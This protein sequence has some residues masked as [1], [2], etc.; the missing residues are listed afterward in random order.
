MAT[1]KKT[2]RFN[3]NDFQQLLAN[4]EKAKNSSAS[5]PSDSSSTISSDGTGNKARQRKKT[6]ASSSQ[7]VALP[8]NTES[9]SFNSL[10]DPSAV[11]P[12]TLAQMLGLPVKPAKEKRQGV[13]QTPIMTAVR[14]CI[15]VAE[16]S[17][18]HLCLM[19]DGAR[20]FT[21]NDLFAILQVRKYVV[22][23]Y[24]KLWHEITRKA[25]ASLGAQKPHFDGPCHISLFRQGTRLIDRDSFAVMFKYIIDALRDDE[26]QNYIGLLPDDNPNIIFSDEKHQSI[27]PP[28]IGIRI[29]LIEPAP[30]LVNYQARDLFNNGALWDHHLVAHPPIIPLK[31]TKVSKKASSKDQDLNAPTE[32]ALP[33]IEKALEAKEKAPTAKPPLKDPSLPK[34]PKS[35]KTVAKG[36]ASLAA[37][38]DKPKSPIKTKKSNK[39]A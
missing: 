14:D 23:G 17:P 29:D 1:P 36:Q 24:K 10:E 34:S 25:L 20:L 38:G 37:S 21:L 13:K 33:S 28:I 3:E 18:K 15:C 16:A 8:P 30:T 26:K 35:V 39:E 31:K 9:P 27:G 19:F 12:V 6:A 11:D 7:E 4:L 5:S 32:V 22:F 2:A